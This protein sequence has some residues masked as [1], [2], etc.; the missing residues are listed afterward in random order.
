MQTVRLTK[1]RNHRVYRGHPWIY[2]TE[3]A[4]QYPYSPGELVRV[5]DHNN[6]FVGIGYYNSNSQIAVRI[7]SFH[8]EE[9]NYDWIKKKIIKAY[10][11]RSSVVSNTDAYRLIYG[12][13][14]QI[15]GLIV[16]RFGDYLVLQSLTYGIEKLKPL[17]VEALMEVIKPR[18]IYERSDVPVRTKEGLPLA[19]GLLA[20]EVPELVVIN[21][22]GFKFS[23]NIKEGHKTGYFLDQ[24]ENRL[25]LK[26][27]F[28]GKKV[29]DCFCHTGAFSVYAAGFGAKE[30]IGVDISSEAITRAQ[31]NAVLNGFQDKIFFIEANCFDYL[32][33]LEKNRANFDIVILDPPAFT[34][35]KE[36]LPGAIRGYK[37]INLRAL[38]LLNEGGIL[39]TSSCSYH[40]TEDLFW[41]V[42]SEAAFDA[43]KRVRIIEARRQAKDHPM[44]LSSPETYYLKFFILQVIS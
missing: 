18:G 35:S 11:Y 13:A 17:I 29:L 23:V 5:L 14:D 39:V 20:G 3:L 9:I 8:D 21:E 33:E 10:Q 30:V 43:K 40:L 36:A 26:P 4:A 15:P 37:E 12:E 42:I 2:K 1:G 6:R 34:K 24:R 16:D 41:N 32:R 19:T 7:M 28:H 44:L 27:F 22:N 31:E 38:K 25:A